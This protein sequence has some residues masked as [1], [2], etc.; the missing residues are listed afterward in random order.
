MQLVTRRSDWP[1]WPPGPAR[2]AS[3]IICESRGMKGNG[4][5]CGVMS[6]V[7]KGEKTSN[8]VGYL[9]TRLYMYI[10]Y[11]HYMISFLLI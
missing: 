1:D 3:A 8:F 9:H 6:G 11:L 2:H 5:L 4:H 7:G 10:L